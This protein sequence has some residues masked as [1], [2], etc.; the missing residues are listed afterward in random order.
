MFDPAEVA[1]SWIKAHMWAFPV[2]Y[3]DPSK[4]KDSKQIITQVMT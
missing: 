4:R 3:L 1:G 2:C